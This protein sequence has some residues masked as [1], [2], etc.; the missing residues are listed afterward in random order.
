MSR[1]M[2]NRGRNSRTGSATYISSGWLSVL[3]VN[4]FVDSGSRPA[5]FQNLVLVGGR[6]EA[7]QDRERS[8]LEARTAPK[9]RKKTK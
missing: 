6:Q 7:G 3:S 4:S 5:E 2:I 9:R 1:F 8:L